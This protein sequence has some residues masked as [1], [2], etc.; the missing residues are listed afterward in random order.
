M[1][2]TIFGLAGTG[3]STTGECLAKMLGYEFVSSGNIFR[4]RAKELGLSLPEFSDLCQKDEK[5]DKEL[6]RKMTTYGRSKENF[7]VESRLAWYTIP[8][9]IKIKL[10]CSFEKRVERV[11]LRDEQSISE[12]KEK[13]I[14]REGTEKERYKSYYGIKDYSN[15]NHFDYIIDTTDLTIEG[16]ALKIREMLK[17]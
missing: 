8:D 4:A 12:A 11:A 17:I 16:T 9:S 6:D 2:I 3:T 1:K 7:V 13:I 15:D 14:H 5:E 10:T